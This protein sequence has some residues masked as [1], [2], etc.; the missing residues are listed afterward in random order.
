MNP[1]RQKVTF[2][3]N[4]PELLTLEF[5]P[6]SQARPG[7]WGEQFMYWLAD[8]KTLWADPELHERIKATGAKAGDTVLVAKQKRQSAGG[9]YVVTWSIQPVSPDEL[10]KGKAA[11]DAATPLAESMPPPATKPKYL[12]QATPL[13]KRLPPEKFAPALPPPTAAIAAPMNAPRMS[14]ALRAAID[15]CTETGFNATSED[16]RALAITIYIQSC[17]GKR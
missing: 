17:G 12:P 1:Q 2:N 13:E 6:P 15:A 7:K 16:I 9:G 8:E 3:L 4:I 11:L 5:D 14:A 10:A